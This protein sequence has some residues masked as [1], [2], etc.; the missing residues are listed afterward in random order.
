MKS[1]RSVLHNVSIDSC[2]CISRVTNVL[3]KTATLWM[4]KICA[5]VGSEFQD[6]SDMQDDSTAVEQHTD[7]AFI[8]YIKGEI[9]DPNVGYQQTGPQKVESHYL[10]KTTRKKN[11][12]K[13]RKVKKHTETCQ[14]RSVARIKPDFPL[15]PP[16]VEELVFR[17]KRSFVSTGKC[18]PGSTQPNHREYLGERVFS[19]HDHQSQGCYENCTQHSAAHDS[20]PVMTMKMI[21]VNSQAEADRSTYQYSVP[22]ILLVVAVVNALVVGVE[23]FCAHVHREWAEFND[24][25]G[26][27]GAEVQYTEPPLIA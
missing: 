18:S 11:N 9:P 1:E 17:R 20:K 19:V 6:F 26:H 22:G 7:S 27:K 24:I 15:K 10:K 14:Q 21:S 12:T 16:P 2:P 13:S 8:A 25:C 23:K 5:Y 3:P 4:H